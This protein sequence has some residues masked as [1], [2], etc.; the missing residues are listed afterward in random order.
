[1]KYVCSIRVLTYDCTFVHMITPFLNH[2]IFIV[3]RIYLCTLI[4]V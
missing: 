3:D 4:S 1:M 2:V